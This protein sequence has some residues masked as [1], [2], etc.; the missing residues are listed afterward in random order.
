VSST[1]SKRRKYCAAS[2]PENQNRTWDPGGNPDPEWR[3]KLIKINVS[4]Y[5]YSL[6]ATVLVSDVNVADD[7]MMDVGEASRTE[8]DSHANMSV[9]GRH[10]YI[11]S[12]TEKVAEVNPFTPDYDSMEVPIIDAAVRYEYPYDGA[13]Y[14]LVIRNALYV[15]SMKNNLMPPFC[16]ERGWGQGQRRTQDSHRRPY[17]RRSLDMFPGNC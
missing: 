11:I 6:L 4:S 13:S 16:D 17:S 3:N 15:P 9:V 12:Y 8:L 7:N 14:I 1:T 2:Q 10:A 5:I